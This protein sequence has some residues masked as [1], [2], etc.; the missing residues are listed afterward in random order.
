MSSLPTQILSPGV[1]NDITIPVGTYAVKVSNTSPYDLDYSGFGVWG[2]DWIPAGTEYMLYSTVYSS[3]QLSMTLVN[4]RNVSPANPGAILLAAYPNKDSLPE[5]NWPITIPFQTVSTNVGVTGVNNTGNPPGTNWMTVQPSD[6]SLPTFLADNSGNFTV[7]QDNAGTETVAIDIQSGANPHTIINGSMKGGLHLGQ[8]STG[9][10]IDTD[11]NG[12]LYLK[13]IATVNPNVSFQPVVGNSVAQIFSDGLHL[14]S[15]GY[16]KYMDPGVV[17]NGGTSGTAT[18]YQVEIG[19]VKRTIVYLNNF[20]TGA[21]AQN[22][23]F[24]TAYT[25]GALIRTGGTGSSATTSHISFVASGV[26]QNVN[27]LTTLA[28]GGGTVTNQAWILQYS[29]GE[30]PTAFDA[31]QFVAGGSAAH[32]GFIIIEGQ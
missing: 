3:G 17:L 32:S 18:L 21:S 24:P 13:S 5:G 22:L 11:A 30:C 2:D 23:S 15:G 31:I 6:G 10:T 28:A 4:N 12:N 8:L 1:S 26:V 19:N 14:G 16:T 25:K 7:R 27:V 9:D 20:R 29:Y